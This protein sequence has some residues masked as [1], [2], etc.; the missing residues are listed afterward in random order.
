[1]EFVDTSAWFAYSLPNDPDHNRVRSCFRSAKGRLLTTDYCLDEILTLLMARGEIRRA[2][3][4]GRPLLEG[5]LARLHFITPEQIRR[6]WILF[7]QRASAGWSFTDCTSRV[8]M[9][10]LGI[11]TAVAL[12][13][14][15]RQF[16]GTVVVP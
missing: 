12:D 14:H 3:N 15:F 11:R 10:D 13:E 6:A 9:T 2:I 8:V 16:E 5:Q 1:M 4:L 7:E